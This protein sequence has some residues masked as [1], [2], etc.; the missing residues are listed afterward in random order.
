[1]HGNELKERLRERLYLRC[2]MD[3]GSVGHVEFWIKRVGPSAYMRLFGSVFPDLRGL[4]KGS[5]PKDAHEVARQYELLDR[6]IIEGVVDEDEAGQPIDAPFFTPD[7]L[8][9]LEMTERAAIAN[10]ILA[11]S[12]LGKKVTAIAD[13]FPDEAGDVVTVGAAG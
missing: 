13:G 12:G 11:W 1:M 10:E 3:L 8:A 6:V 9:S 2:E 7:L 4:E 5:T